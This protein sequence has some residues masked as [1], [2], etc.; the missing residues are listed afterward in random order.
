M[1]E[2]AQV[3]WGAYNERH[4]N[5]YRTM[6]LDLLSLFLSSEE[7]NL[8]FSLTGEI[9]Y[10]GIRLCQVGLTYGATNR[11]NSYFSTSPH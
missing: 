7:N 1:G 5:S 2:V 9:K 8:N 11:C 6:F 3:L 10:S 4:S